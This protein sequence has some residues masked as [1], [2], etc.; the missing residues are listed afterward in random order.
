MDN[1]ST[2]NIESQRTKYGTNWTENNFMTLLNWICIA[3]FY[4]DALEMTINYYRMLI[5]NNVVLGLIL[6]TASGTISATRFGLESNTDLALIFNILFTTMSFTIAIFTGIIKVYQIQEQLENFIK[7]KQD[8]IV[9][10]TSIASELQ[11]PVKLRHDVFYVI[12]KNKTKYLDLLKI[13]LDIPYF[14]KEKVKKKL[15]GKT[16]LNDMGI[17]TR[18]FDA[19]TLSDIILEISS[20]EGYRFLKEHTEYIMNK[21]ISEGKNDLHSNNENITNSIK[22]KTTDLENNKNILINSVKFDIENQSSD[23]QDSIESKNQSVDLQ[24]LT[25]TQ[26]Q[27][28]DSQNIIE[29]K[30]QSVD[31]QDLTNTLN[32][33][34]DS[35]DIIESKNQSVDLQDLT[36]TLNQS[37]D[38]QNTDSQDIIESKNQSVDLQDLTN[39]LN[40]STDSQ[41]TDINN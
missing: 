20:V 21:N 40:Q 32:Q 17:S 7:V 34:T 25:N 3:A 12:I 1:E 23:S 26:N 15:Q 37:T 41:D 33:S 38:S 31:L 6:S 2:E 35:Q 28:T 5:R 29:S 18:K 13:D 16:Y 11:L 36:N 4:I 30:N 10:S 8:W 24:D 9:F 14:I 39:T 27:N 22:N 19:C